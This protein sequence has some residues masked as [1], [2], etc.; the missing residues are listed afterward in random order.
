[1]S[2]K[3]D[4]KS[5]LNLTYPGRYNVVLLNDEI[6]PMEFVVELLIEIFNKNAMD[7]TNITMEVHEKG[8]G[9]AGSYPSEIAEQ[10]HVEVVTMVRQAGWPL[11]AIVEKM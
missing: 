1:M 9:L 4:T 8:R 2:A 10:K 6:T 7:A 3:E 11:E 5:R